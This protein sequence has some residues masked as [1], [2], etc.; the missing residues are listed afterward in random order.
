MKTCIQVH[1]PAYNHTYINLVQR[2]VSFS[3]HRRGQIGS[4]ACLR[5]VGHSLSFAL[6]IHARRVAALAVVLRGLRQSV[7]AGRAVAR[8]IRRLR[9]L[10]TG[11]SVCCRYLLKFN[12]F[13]R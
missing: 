6:L 9:E 13:R 12:K 2:H 3:V 10:L 11:G 4:S 1:S 5:L 8:A 7:I